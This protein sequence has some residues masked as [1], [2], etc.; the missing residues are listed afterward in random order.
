MTS[1]LLDSSLEPEQKRFTESIRANGQSLLSLINNILD[2]SKIEAKKLDLEEMDFNLLEMLE[3]LDSAM[4]WQARSKGLT[5]VWSADPG[6]P[7]RV[8]GDPTRLRQILINLAGNAIKF[9]KSGS[10]EIRTAPGA[11]PPTPAGAPAAGTDGVSLRFTVRDTG[12]G[13]APEKI[14]HLFN[15]FIQADASSTRKYGGSGLGL[16]IAKQLAE[17]MGGAIGVTSTPGRGS[18]FWF[19]IRL[20]RPLST[21]DAQSAA[22]HAIHAIQPLFH[23]C[24]LRVLLAEDNPVNQEVTL[25]MLDKMGLPADVAANG[26]EALQAAQTGVYDLIL[27][28]IQ[29]PDMD[30]LTASRKIREWEAASRTGASAKS[31]GYPAAGAAIPIIAMT[32]HALADD[33]A[34]CLA[35]GMNDYIAK[36]VVPQ[37][38][39]AVLAKWLRQP[40]RPA[41]TAAN[42]PVRFPPRPAIRGIRT[43]RRFLT[44]PAWPPAC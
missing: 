22:P 28:D 25:G 1:L 4:S 36:P 24:N 9:T 12:I 8:R 11:A 44:A 21:E 14:K 38:L 2:Y 32:A 29:M 20:R 34:K 6:V 5:I 18:E 10:V 27:M 37:A 16:A 30:G 26:A 42:R 33:R 35:A 43:R 13:I 39:G 15:R 7:A 41:G 31:K 3:D 19:T 17:L 23:G 40:A